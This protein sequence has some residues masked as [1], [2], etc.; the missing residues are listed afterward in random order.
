MRHEKKIQ[1]FLHCPAVGVCGSHCA[2]GDD[3]GFRT[4]RSPLC[5]HFGQYGQDRRFSHAQVHLFGDIPAVQGQAAARV[6][7]RW[8]VL[9]I[10]ESINFL[11]LGFFYGPTLSGSLLLNF[12]YSSMS[13]KHK[14]P[15]YPSTLFSLWK[16]LWLERR[17]LGWNC[18]T[19]Y[20]KQP[21][22]SHTQRAMLLF[23]YCTLKRHLE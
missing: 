18:M 8:S 20:I 2:D 17:I 14:F 3:A 12:M 10:D 23:A 16:I 22:V 4:K 5:G 7:V 15:V 9:P 13:S 19:G 11:T 6:S 21:V 1:N